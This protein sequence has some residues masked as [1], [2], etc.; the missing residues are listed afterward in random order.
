V[1]GAR[2][3]PM[4]AGR[5]A[6]RGRRGERPRASVRWRVAAAVAGALAVLAVLLTQAPASLADV[7][8]AQ[9]TQGRVRL[10]EAGGTVWSGRGRIV[11][12]D[13]TDAAA[14]ASRFAAT[15]PGVVLPGVFRWRLSPW[16]LAFGMLD[17]RIEHDSMRQ[18]VL[19]TGRAGELRATPGAIALPPVAL[20]RLGSP[21]NTIRPTGA[22]TVS[23]E[24]VTLRSGRFDG[25]AAIEL[26]EAASALTPV[27]PLGAYR[28]EIVGSGD[29][30]QV[31]MTTLQGPLRLDGSGTWDARSGLRFSAAAQ[32]DEAERARLQ[33]LLGLLGRR[34]GERTIIKIGA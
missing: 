9:V 24:S 8:L 10:A 23:W 4:A 19:L 17:A 5:R 6:A 30:A 16:P 2:A 3:T 25:R 22:L 12:A 31:A 26:R 29:R 7:A 32:A 34:E 1:I 13:V 27:R 11:L 33:P 15:V 14:G 21:W 18:P 28:I 20:D